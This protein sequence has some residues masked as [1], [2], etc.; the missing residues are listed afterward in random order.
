MPMVYTNVIF[1]RLND[2][3]KK[4]LQS[5]IDEG[6]KAF[7][8]KF[9]FKVY[10]DYLHVSFLGYRTRV[11]PPLE[12]IAEM[13]TWLGKTDKDVV[14]KIEW[15]DDSRV[16]GQRIRLRKESSSSSMLRLASP[17]DGRRLTLFINSSYAKKDRFRESEDD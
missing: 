17:I 11:R 3:G 12:P 10:W 1:E 8:S 16:V 6:K 4:Q 15:E 13:I 9:G 7:S 14:A 2:E 5:A